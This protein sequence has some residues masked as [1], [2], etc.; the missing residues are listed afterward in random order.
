[1][2]FIKKNKKNYFKLFSTTYKL[3]NEKL[4]NR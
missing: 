3:K 1:M 4:E 2:F